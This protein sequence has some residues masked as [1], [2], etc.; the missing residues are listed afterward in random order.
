MSKFNR[1]K[2]ERGHLL[3]VLFSVTILFCSCDI[4]NF[5]MPQPIDKENI[6]EFPEEFQGRW[7]NAGMD[8]SF[9][10]SK[11]YGLL[12]SHDTTEIST[13]SLSK[14]NLK[15]EYL[16]PTLY[17]SFRTI[18][19]DSEKRPFDTVDN[20]V[21]RGQYIYEKF[22]GLGRRYRY[23]I[24]HDTITI[25]KND[26]TCIDLGRN[27]FLRQINK[28]LY[29]LNICNRILGRDANEYENWW[30]VILLENQANKCIRSWEMTSK[31]ENMSCMFY[32]ETD[33]EISYYFDC[34]WTAADMLRLV[35]EGYFEPS[36][37]FHN[38]E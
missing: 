10:V 27:A 26:T 25:F 34:Q 17:N 15:G 30:T 18:Y 3:F 19:Y 32:A 9:F 23:I 31:M 20:Y 8:E 37:E 36:S 21:L 14:R 1:D 38:Y 28:N 5:S 33:R 7:I 4:H 2:Y 12:I 16:E 6:Y 22:S 35:K 13:E 24:H 29:S 11:K